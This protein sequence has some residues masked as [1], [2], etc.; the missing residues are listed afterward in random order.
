MPSL[1]RWAVR[2]PYGQLLW[3]KVADVKAL[4]PKTFQIQLKAP[5][6]IMLAALGQP[7]GAAFIMPKK[8][9]ETDPFK[10]IDD[11]T[12]SGPFIFVK[13][14]W[15]PGDKTVYVR[16]PKYKPRPSRPRAWPAA[17]SPRSTGSNGWR[18]PTSR[19][20]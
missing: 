9:A 14:E 6:G 4:D 18:S 2:M 17:R 1:K 16:N 8:V 10:Q 7:S 19:R 13:D 11:Y 3:T 20:R 15:K 12:G 5:T